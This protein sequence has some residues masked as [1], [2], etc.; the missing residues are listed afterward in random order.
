MGSGV[1]KRLEFLSLI[2]AAAGLRQGN[3]ARFDLRPARSGQRLGAGTHPLGLGTGR[4]GVLL[5]PAAAESSTRALPLLIALHGAGGAGAR[6]IRHLSPF[7]EAHGMLLLAPDARRMTW[8][9][10]RGTYGD[11]VAFIE[12]AVQWTFERCLVDRRRLF[13]EGFSDGASYALGLGLANGDLF[14]RIIAFSP[15]FIPDAGITNGAPAVFLSHGTA[16][17]I[18]PI[19]STSWRIVPRLRAAGLDVTYR[20]F[21]GEHTVPEAV[22]REAFDWLLRS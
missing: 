15:G 5:V 16:D 13:L 22:V 10:I 2:G 21:E 7:A 8:D 17:S 9:A 3:P 11:D 6:R 14:R 1:V 19:E 20:E 12:R 4:D 18:L